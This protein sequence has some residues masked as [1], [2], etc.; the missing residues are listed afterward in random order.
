[1]YVSRLE[2]I[3]N[4]LSLTH[5]QQRNTIKYTRSD[6]VGLSESSN[7]TSTSFYIPIGWERER[8]GKEAYY[9]GGG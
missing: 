6:V 8:G 2:G 5:V 3:A 9:C 4:S 7:R 1:M